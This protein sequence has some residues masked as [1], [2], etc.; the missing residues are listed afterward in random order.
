ME[1]RFDDGF[2]RDLKRIRDSDLLRRVERAIEGVE[3][4]PTISEIPG[5]EGMRARGRFYRIRMGEY[6]IGNILHILQS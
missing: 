3:A 2:H 4:A 5:I 6:R 1:V